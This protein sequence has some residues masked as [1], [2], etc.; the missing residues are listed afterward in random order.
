MQRVLTELEGMSDLVIIDT[1]AALAV[2]DALP[3]LQRASGAVLIA[4]MKTT[5]RASVRRLM[6]VLREAHSTVLGVVATGVSSQ[7]G[8]GGHAYT[9]YGGASTKGRLNGRTRRAQERL[10]GAQ[11]GRHAAVAD[12]PE[13]H[14]L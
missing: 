3:L 7:G 5:D 13:Q 9:Y 4:R 12:P 2:G 1:P 11:A 8:Y 14:E 6:R 10:F